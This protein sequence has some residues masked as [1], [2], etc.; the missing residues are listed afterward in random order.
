M[1]VGSVP[2]S[3]VNDSSLL[4]LNSE[5]LLLVIF[6]EPTIY[7]VIKNFDSI[8]DF[9]SVPVLSGLDEL[10][11]VTSFFTVSQSRAHSHDVNNLSYF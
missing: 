9:P 11:P 2:V 1:T 5:F 6:T 10:F 7:K 4:N 3:S 8:T